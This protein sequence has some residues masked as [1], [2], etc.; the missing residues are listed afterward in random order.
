MVITGLE[1]VWTKISEQN[2]SAVFKYISLNSHQ[3]ARK[4]IKDIFTAMDKVLLNPEQH[5]LDKFK[6]NND[7]TYRAFE[8]HKLR[9][10]YRHQ[11]NIIRVLRIRH[12]KMEPQ[13]Y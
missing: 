9:I 4:V 8:V 13:N 11:K 7:G 10:V 3:N 12:T 5:N 2:L 6:K 1:L